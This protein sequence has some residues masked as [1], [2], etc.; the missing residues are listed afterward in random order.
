MQTPESWQ[1]NFFAACGKTAGLIGIALNIGLFAAKLVIGLISG[2]VAITADAVNNLT[3]ASGSVLTLLGFRLAEKPADEDH[4]FGHARVEYITGLA[5]A[6]LILLIGV[7][8]GK[9]SIEKILHPAPVAFSVPLA[10]VLLLSIAVKLWMARFNRVL[11]RRIDSAALS[12]AASD[13]RNDVISTAAVLAACVIGALTGVHLDGPMGL[14]VA[15]FIVWSGIGVARETISPLLGENADPAL[16]KAVVEDVMAHELVL[17]VHDVMVHDYGPGQ[18]FATLHVEMDRREDPLVCHDIIDNIEREILTRHGIHLTIHY[19]P[20]EMDDA[21]TD[22]PGER[23]GPAP[24]DARLPHGP[25][26]R[27]HESDLRPGGPAGSGPGGAAPFHCRRRADAARQVLLR[28]HL[29]FPRLQ[30]E[31]TQG[32]ASCGRAEKTCRPDVSPRQHS[33][34]LCPVPAK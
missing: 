17:G 34:R 6:A 31:L 33:R 11:G 1:N 16:V 23:P 15:A 21:E 13:S 5:V 30:P 4:P 25:G 7:E 3:D 28:G 19:D 14:A 22:R 18:K 9:S 27:S 26:H 32:A 8:L 2:S 20:L 24:Q 29:R 12:A 10:L